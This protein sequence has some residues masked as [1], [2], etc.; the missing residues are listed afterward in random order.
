MAGS[1]NKPSWP[2]APGIANSNEPR[3]ITLTS[4]EDEE[5]MFKNR[6]EVAQ[7]AGLKHID[8]IHGD[9][10][11]YQGSGNYHIALAIY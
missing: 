6:M 4:G 5:D 1:R 2:I 7:A 3:Q 9:E 10:T 11:F 8:V